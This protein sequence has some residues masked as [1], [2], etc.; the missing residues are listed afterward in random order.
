MRYSYGWN[1][2]RKR[3]KLYKC[4]AISKGGKMKN[5]NELIKEYN[6]ILN[7]EYK[8]IKTIMKKDNYGH[9]YYGAAW[10][11][12]VSVDIVGFKKIV[13][14][15]GNQEVV[16]I[17]QLF[18]DT[19]I[20]T[21]KDPKFIDIFRD[22]YFMGKKVLVVFEAKTTSEISLALEFSYYINSQINEV[23][24]SILIEK[25]PLLK[26]FKAGIGMWV[27]NDNTLVYS[28]QKGTEN[29]NQSTLIGSSIDYASKL[30]SIANRKGYPAIMMNSLIN[31]NLTSNG[32]QST[33][34]WMKKYELSGDMGITYG[35]NIV[36]SMYN[37]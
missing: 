22:S 4:E 25:I 32:K 14:K 11:T 37:K 24:S 7:L 26:D 17:V 34:K 13:K 2:K 9:G 15:L 8:E 23:L 5:K 20:S 28:G 1:Y 33:E 10:A 29:F 31:I 19:V 27:S 12:V 36:K 6:D 21:A 18:S 30:S 35:G 3:N 16:K